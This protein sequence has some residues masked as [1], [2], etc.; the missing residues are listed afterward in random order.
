MVKGAMPQRS[1]FIITAVSFGYIAQPCF[2]RRNLYRG[3]NIRRGASL[4]LYWSLV[5]TKREMCEWMKVTQSC[6]TLCNPMDCS[7]P[8]SPFHGVLQARILEWVA[9]SFSRWSSQ[10]KDWTQVSHIAGRHFTIWATRKAPIILWI[11]IKLNLHV[12]HCAQIVLLRVTNSNLS[13]LPDIVV[14][15]WNLNYCHY[16]HHLVCLIT[17]YF[18]KRKK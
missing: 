8:G 13:T 4:G 6:P 1:H 18:T 17:V 3:V 5:T 2:C 10:P 15:V 14:D 12:Y 7:P 9:I 16:Q 11:Y